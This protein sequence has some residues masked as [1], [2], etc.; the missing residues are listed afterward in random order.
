MKILVIGDLHG[1]LP[2]NLPKKN[3]DL[4]LLTG[5]LGKA[6]LMRKMFFEKEK[7]KKQGLS[8]I[9]YASV[10]KK[11]AFMEA[12]NSTMKIIKTLRKIAPVFTI[13]GNVESSNFETKKKAKKLKLKLPFLSNDL[14]KIEGVKLINN[15]FVN[16]EGV[17]IG[18]LEYFVD[19][20][21]VKEFRPVDFKNEMKS[22]KIETD[23]AKKVLKEFSEIDILICHQPPYGILDKI[24]FPGAPKYWEGK[25][26]G[27]KA[28]LDYISKEQPRYVF[29][30]HIHE[31][32]GEKK[33][34]KTKIVNLGF[35]GWKVLDIK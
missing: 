2:K 25:H 1:E 32:K 33:I 3:I 7:R 22:A 31:A 17:K 6:D 12:Y 27:S 15:L 16:F 14:K 28:I 23:K 8:E 26:A 13:F 19:V 35:R 4:I 5:D 9:K 34:G 29:C 30:G 18:G 24:N 10:Q 20:S 21:W 11:K